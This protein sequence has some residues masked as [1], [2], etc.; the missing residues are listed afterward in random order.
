MIEVPCSACGT[1]WTPL[2]RDFVTGLWK[3]C[4]T[5]RGDPD[6]TG[7]GSPARPSQALTDDPTAS[8]ATR[9]DTEQEHA[10]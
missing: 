6:A 2:R 10:A 4:P 7:I 5:C 9:S 8:F 3:L 1:Q